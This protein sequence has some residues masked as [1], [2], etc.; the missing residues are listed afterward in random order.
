MPSGTLVIQGHVIR[1]KALQADSQTHHALKH[2]GGASTAVDVERGAALTLGADL[3]PVVNEVSSV[4]AAECLHA[5]GMYT[6]AREA[7]IGLRGRDP[8]FC[9]V[10]CRV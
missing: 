5:S 8:R 10:P 6:R 3:D 9:S 4:R 7:F 1:G 2:P